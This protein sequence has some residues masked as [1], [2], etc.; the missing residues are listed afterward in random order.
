MKRLFL[1]GLVVAG[2][3][4]GAALVPMAGCDSQTT[5]NFDMAPDFAIAPQV[6]RV[7]ANAPTCCMVTRGAQTALYLANPS[8][9]S[10]R[11]RTSGEKVY[12]GELHLVNAFGK[13]LILGSDVP[14]FDYGFAPDG[15]AVFFVQPAGKNN[16][17]SLQAQIIDYPDLKASAPVTVI[18]DGIQD[19]ALNQQSFFSP[20]GQKLIIGALPGAVQNSPDLHVVDV[21]SLTDV[22]QVGSGAFNYLELVT[23]DDVMVFNNSTASTTPGTPSVV[24]LYMIPLSI[25]GKG[26]TK[27]AM[28]DEHV[29]SANTMNDGTTL[30]Y[31]RAGGEL[32]LFD[33]RSQTRL[34]VAD[35]AIVFTSGPTARGPIIWVSSDGSMHGAPK[36]TYSSVLDLPAGSADLFTPVVFSPDGGRLYWFKH[37]NQSNANGDLWTVKLPNG[38]P[39]IIGARISSA[40][41]TFY[42]DR[43]YYVRNV[44]ETGTAG[45]LVSAEMD[46][47][48]PVVMASGV[49]L[50]SLQM[51][52]PQR[53]NT[54]SNSSIEA[55]DLTFSQP[56]PLFASLTAAQRMLDSSNLDLM[57]MNNSSSV[58][59]ALS[60]GT[61]AAGPEGVINAAVHDGMF[62]FSDDGSTLGY[63]GDAAWSDDVV[64]FI[65]QLRLQPT[66][67]D[68]APP[69]P[70]LDGVA[71]MGPI[72][73]RALFVSAPANAKPGIYFIKF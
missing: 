18:P 36:L 45:E 53:A 27:P 3:T 35:D 61:L 28:I 43:F 63:V 25:F 29:V 42:N 15:S 60:F 40:D 56:P 8:E 14:A 1:L 11:Q 72:R 73:D 38:T 66:I 71:E 24:G 65:G 17:F 21:P 44:D 32:R 49:K 68:R 62:R 69:D 46:G 51:T 7:G 41:F 6:T 10:S 9:D 64:N 33:T 22:A 20:S 59:G 34:H 2:L 26:S 12:T 67:I 55:H 30:L 13:D 5:S 31:T 58:L 57:P 4:V 54:G 52:A 19:Y 47:S 16:N 37:L 48:N 50:G 39:Q 23:N 70:N